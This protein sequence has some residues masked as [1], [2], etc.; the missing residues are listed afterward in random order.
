MMQA[1]SREF[2]ADPD[3]RGNKEI[4]KASH[5]ISDNELCEEGIEQRAEQSITRKS[6]AQFIRLCHHAHAVC[7][8]ASATFGPHEVSLNNPTCR[9]C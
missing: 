1:G 7:F 6:S 2:L 3:F 4:P 8:H 5:L 9:A